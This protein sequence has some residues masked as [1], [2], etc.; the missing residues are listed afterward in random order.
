MIYKHTHNDVRTER[1]GRKSPILK[2]FPFNKNLP[3]NKTG[4][5][6]VIFQGAIKL[7]TDRQS[8][9]GSPIS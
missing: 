8:N 7:H 3:T 9:G 1:V 4:D 6:L 2:L 5:S